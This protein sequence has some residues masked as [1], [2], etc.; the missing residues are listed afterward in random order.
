MKVGIAINGFAIQG[1]AEGSIWIQDDVCIQ[2]V[3]S[4]AGM[5][6]LKLD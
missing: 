5:L 3:D 4:V 1:C 2:E 6:T